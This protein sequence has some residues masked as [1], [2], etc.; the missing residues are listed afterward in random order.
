MNLQIRDTSKEI[1]DGYMS[2]MEKYD[3]F[4]NEPSPESLNLTLS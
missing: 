1:Y 4:G 2:S 3:G